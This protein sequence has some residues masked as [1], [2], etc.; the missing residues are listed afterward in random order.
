MN[1]TSLDSRDRAP[2]H[3][4]SG[5]T[6]GHGRGDA[7]LPVTRVTRYCRPVMITS[8]RSTRIR[9]G[10]RVRFGRKRAAPRSAAVSPG[11]R[12]MQAT[13]RAGAASRPSFSGRAQSSRLTRSGA[14]AA[15]RTSPTPSCSSPRTTRRG[16][17]ASSWRWPAD[18][19]SSDP[20]ATSPGGCRSERGGDAGGDARRGDRRGW[21]DGD[22]AGRRAPAGGRRRRHPRAPQ[23]TGPGGLARRRV[24]V[25]SR[26]FSNRMACLS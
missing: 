24:P 11:H 19:C 25:V 10:N 15:P 7:E 22:D 5:A 16:S 20:T 4:D 1:M 2:V 6:H 17:V 18:R 12:R 26:P 23:F 21:S 8:G 14:S 3:H 13:T 9:T